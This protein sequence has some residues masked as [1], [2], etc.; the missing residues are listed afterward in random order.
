MPVITYDIINLCYRSRIVSRK[1]CLQICSLFCGKVIW[2]VDVFM[3]GSIRGFFFTGVQYFKIRMSEIYKQHNN[4]LQTF[5][6]LTFTVSC[7]IIHD[8]QF[9]RT[10]I[11]QEENSG[12][13][14]LLACDSSDV[15]GLELWLVW[16]VHVAKEF[17]TLLN[18]FG[19]IWPR[20]A[21]TPI[22]SWRLI[23]GYT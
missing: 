8:W 6:L 12:Q 9:A 15:Y 7:T 4:A 18:R 19:Y 14:S 10:L 1:K 16:S 2:P 3:F 17:L 21:L 5:H 11:P 22:P 23:S 13:I 20:A